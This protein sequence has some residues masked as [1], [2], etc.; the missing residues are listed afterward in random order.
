MVLVCS[1]STQKIL[2][3]SKSNKGGSRKS[4]QTPTQTQTLLPLW[5]KS[6]FL[7]LL[8]PTFLWAVCL[9]RGRR[10]PRVAHPGVSSPPPP[11]TALLGQG[12]HGDGAQEPSGGTSGALALKSCPF[13]Q[14]QWDPEGLFV[15]PAHFNYPQGE[16][17]GRGSPHVLG[18]SCSFP[19][20]HTLGPL[21]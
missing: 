16:P 3:I 5:V 6:V 9:W 8:F 17:L 1:K 11:P 13:V 19:E 7:W 21:A 10:L 15:C 20:M 14:G 18:M 12:C 4:P 2:P